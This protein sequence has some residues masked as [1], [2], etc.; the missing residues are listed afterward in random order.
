M[1]LDYC[2]IPI[3]VG[4]LYDRYTI[5]QI[6]K[7]KITSLDKLVFIEKELADLQY[8]INKFPI[9]DILKHNM[10][11]VN[12]VLWEIEDNIREKERKQE[13]D[14]EFI[15]LARMVYKTNDERHAIK[16]SIN[17]FFHSIHE[18]KS[19]AKY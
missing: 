2:T 9:D 4:E 8:F 15:S 12:V 5:L 19:Y 18:I 14:A 17:H 10:K 7:E 6:K 13:F 11:M 3:S 16:T 1:D